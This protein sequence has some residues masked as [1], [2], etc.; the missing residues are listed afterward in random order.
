MQF[1]A[2]STLSQTTRTL[3][4]PEV[5]LEIGDNV[6]HSTLVE[7]VSGLNDMSSTELEEV[8]EG[9]EDMESASM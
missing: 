2:R 9:R 7:L 1:V 8:K 5:D 3:P 6:V 4:E